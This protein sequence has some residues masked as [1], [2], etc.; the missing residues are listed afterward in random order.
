ML[1]L[2]RL[3]KRGTE[4]SGPQRR[5]LFRLAAPEKVDDPYQ[6]RVLELADGLAEDEVIEAAM[7]RPDGDDAQPE[8]SGVWEMWC[9]QRVLDALE[10]LKTWGLLRAEEITD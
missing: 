9:R 10:R 3:V 7:A 2:G 6:R 1:N 4:Q 8:G 5:R